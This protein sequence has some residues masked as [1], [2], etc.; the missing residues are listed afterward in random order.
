[1]YIAEGFDMLYTTK[2][3]VPT[4]KDINEDVMAFPEKDVSLLLKAI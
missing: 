2:A 4:E 3:I 1:M